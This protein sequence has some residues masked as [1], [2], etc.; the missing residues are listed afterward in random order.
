MRML[1]NARTTH[2][3]LAHLIRLYTSIAG[4]TESWVGAFRD[5]GVY[6]WI[7]VWTF[8]IVGAIWMWPNTG[9]LLLTPT[10][11]HWCNDSS[12]SFQNL[13]EL[14]QRAIMT[15]NFS[16]VS[17]CRRP[18]VDFRQYTSEQLLSAD[19]STMN[20]TVCDEGMLYDHSQFDFTATE[21]VRFILKC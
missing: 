5:V 3:L 12:P 1:L 15:K 7:I 9:V 4:M 6:Q 16:T 18:D 8:S 20:W 11:P 17:Y 14:Q 13:T 21:Q 2:F 10:V 19:F